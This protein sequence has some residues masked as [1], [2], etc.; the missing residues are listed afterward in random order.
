MW[1]VNLVA[2]SAI[3]FIVWALKYASAHAQR[4]RQRWD[5]TFDDLNSQLN[6]FNATMDRVQA[7]MERIS[8][9]IEETINDPGPRR[10]STFRFPNRPIIPPA[11]DP[12]TDKDEPDQ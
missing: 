4:R 7:E 5:S 3:A 9:E 1:I 8:I 6:D 11:H 10:Q 2:I 12:L